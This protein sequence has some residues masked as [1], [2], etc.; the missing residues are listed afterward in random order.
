M[1][2]TVLKLDITTLPALNRVDE[3][4]REL[5]TRIRSGEF[6]PQ[7]RLPWEQTMAAEFGVSRTVIREAIARLKNEGVVSTRQGSGAFVREWQKCSLNLDPAISK[8]LESVLQI[9]E[10]RL[11]RRLESATRNKRRPSFASGPPR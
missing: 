5:T 3:M 9:A 11:G 2:G 10:L 8:S 7:M 4:T 1:I 6:Q